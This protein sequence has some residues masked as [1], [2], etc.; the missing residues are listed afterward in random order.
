MGF[1]REVAGFRELRNRATDHPWRRELLMEK[2]W[3]CLPLVGRSF[4]RGDPPP[5]E[6]VSVWV[7]Y[8]GPELELF[9]AEPEPLDSQANGP[10]DGGEATRP[11]AAQP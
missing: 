11:A 10:D 6:N 7:G 8:G 3:L 2:V 4:S 1:P 9:G 5:G